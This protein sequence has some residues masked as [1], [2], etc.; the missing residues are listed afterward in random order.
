MENSL[1]GIIV[2]DPAGNITYVN[3]ALVNLYGGND[4]ND[5]VGKHVL[6]L[7]HPAHKQRAFEK[8]M[9]CLKTGVAWRDRFTVLTKQGTTFP[10]EITV[11]PLKDDDGL[12]IGFIDVVRD[13][14]EQVRVEKELKEANRKLETANEKLL[15]LSGLVR[16]DIANKLSILNL[17]VHSAKKSGNATQALAMAEAISAQIT[18]IIEFSRDYE[19]LG[20][21]QLSELDVDKT[22]NEVAALFPALKNMEVV[23]DCRHVK[24][25]ADAL[26][27]ELFYNL[28]DNT[29]KYGEKTTKIKLTC[30]AGDGNLKLVYEDDG[31]GIAEEMREGLFKKGHGKGTGLGL[32]LIKRTMEVYG[33]QIQETGS[34][35]KGA[36]FEITIPEKQ[37]KQSQLQHFKIISS[38]LDVL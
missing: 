36:K 6:D 7:I 20:Q 18:R 8:S 2:G 35:G 33:W 16:H 12:L 37:Q 31:V 34:A 10:V 24:V 19:L 3:T 9:Q 22:F 5:V 1:D 17:S 4:K 30:T 15:V 27:K 28:I 38:I 23:S 11:T 25:L 14:T 13:I 21:Q 32:Y 26:L 29:L